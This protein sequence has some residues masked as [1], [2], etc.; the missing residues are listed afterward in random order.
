MRIFGI[1]VF[2]SIF[3]VGVGYAQDKKNYKVNT[4]AFYNLENLFSTEDDEFTVYQDRNPRGESFYTKDIYQA[5][6]N[7]LAKV[8]SEI[9]TDISGAP[10]AMLGIC[11]I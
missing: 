2:I 5:K 7:N 4:V 6:I 9:G 3:F 1:W 10:R 11:E 8:I